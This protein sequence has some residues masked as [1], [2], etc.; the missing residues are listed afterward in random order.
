METKSST[1]YT[2]LVEHCMPIEVESE[3]AGVTDEWEIIGKDMTYQPTGR[4]EKY[5]KRNGDEIL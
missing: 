5:S 1:F 3:G 2:L 4:G